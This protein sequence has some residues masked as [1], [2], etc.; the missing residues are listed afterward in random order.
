MVEAIISLFKIF[1]YLSLIALVMGF[2]RPVYV[3]WFLDRCNRL[4]VLKL[5]GVPSVV[6]FVIF[7]LL[8]YVF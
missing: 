8:D 7:M 2:I 5:Y 1:F 6:F 4:K 3:L